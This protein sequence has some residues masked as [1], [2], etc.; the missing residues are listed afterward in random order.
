MTGVVAFIP[1][2]MD[3]S[4]LGPRPVELVRSLDQLATAAVG[5]SLV[6]VDL[7]RPGALESAAGLVAAG[8]RVVGFAPHVDDELRNAATGSGVEVVTRSWFFGHLDD[9][10][11]PA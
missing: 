2:L 10:I 4:R 1:D 11:P 6:L 5:A 9:L 7:A 3:R 8:T